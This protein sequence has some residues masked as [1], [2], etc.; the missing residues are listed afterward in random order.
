MVYPVCDIDGRCFVR[1]TDEFRK[2][3]QEYGEMVCGAYACHSAAGVVA[4]FVLRG[5]G[6]RV[7][8]ILVDCHCMLYALFQR[9]FL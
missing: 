8:V 1:H 4:A 9:L 6:R 5:S 2:L 3:G 7:I